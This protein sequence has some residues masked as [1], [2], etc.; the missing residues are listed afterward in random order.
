MKSRC[1]QGWFFLEVPRGGSLPRLFLPSVD[2]YLPP[3]SEPQPLVYSHGSPVSRLYLCLRSPFPLRTLGIGF[4]THFTHMCQRT[5][6]TSGHVH[7]GAG[8]STRTCFGGMFVDSR[9]TWLV[10]SDSGRGL[11]PRHGFCLLGPD[12]EDS[13]RCGC[14]RGF[15]PRNG[16]SSFLGPSS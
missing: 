1:R 3:L 5:C 14:G 2:S 12:R 11:V 6:F 10:H 8:V 9:R 4:G 13:F 16:P 7:R 15:F